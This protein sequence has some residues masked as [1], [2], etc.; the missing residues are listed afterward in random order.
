MVSL[1][2]PVVMSWFKVDSFLVIVSIVLVI[3]LSSLSN[4]M[5]FKSSNPKYAIFADV[6]TLSN[7]ISILNKKIEIK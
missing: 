7:I 6:F 1:L 3:S 2:V 4:F 5:I